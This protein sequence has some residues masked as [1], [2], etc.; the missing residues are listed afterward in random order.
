MKKSQQ[1]MEKNRSKLLEMRDAAFEAASPAHDRMVEAANLYENKDYDKR[2][3]IKGFSISTEKQINP[4]I[5]QAC[6]R[7]FPVFTEQLAKVDLLP[8]RS[9]ASPLERESIEEL[10]SHVALAESIYNETEVIRTLIQ[11]NLVYGIAVSKTIYDR[12]MGI[13]RN[14]SVNPLRFAPDP[15]CTRQDLTDYG[16]AVHSTYQSIEKIRRDFPGATTLG[17]PRKDEEVGKLRVDEIFL[18]RYDAELAKIPNAKDIR[19]MAVAIIV[20]DVPYTA[21][22]D[23]FDDPMPP[24]AVWRGFGELGNNSSGLDFWGIGYPSLM[25]TQQRLLD[26]FMSSYVRTARNLATG[27]LIARRGAIDQEEL[28]NDSGGIIF[29]NKDGNRNAPIGDL[30]QFIQPPEPP[31]AHINAIN[32]ILSSL[33]DMSPSLSPVFTGQAPGPGASGRAI[34]SLQTASLNQLSD[35]LRDL[36]NFRERRT[37]KLAN[38]IQQFGERSLKLFGWKSGN[39]FPSL[40]RDAQLTAFKTSTPDVSALPQ[41]ALGKLQVFGH[42]LQLGAAVKPEKLVEILGLQSA[43]GVSTEDLIQAVMPGGVQQN[44]DQVMGVDPNLQERAA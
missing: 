29:V 7:L 13:A 12:R 11:H 1:K 22:L 15:Y 35:N 43:Y 33:D 20:D 44:A 10:E 19:D 31:A 36:N 3:W 4:K 2:S 9:D 37:R 24:F 25:E 14:V 42:L 18:T 41:T 38:C 5:R 26:E 34:N 16:Y 28:S 23:P 30:V 6:D 8:L 21:W 40:S 27:R 17:K 39:D 32:L